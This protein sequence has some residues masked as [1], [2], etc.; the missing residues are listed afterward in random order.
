MPTGRLLRSSEQS[1]QEMA[2]AWAQVVP[3]ERKRNGGFGDC[4]GGGVKCM[5]EGKDNE[6]SRK[7]LG[8]VA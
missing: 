7:G 1:R 6:E 4:F 5:L 3:G 8:V 2:V